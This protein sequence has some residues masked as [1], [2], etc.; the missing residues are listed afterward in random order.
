MAILNATDETRIRFL[1][2]E[3]M[4]AVG[5]EVIVG[6]SHVESVLNGIMWIESL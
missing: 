6:S 1:Q 3:W 4:K 2:S 5:K